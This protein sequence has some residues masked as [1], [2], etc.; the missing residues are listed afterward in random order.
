MQREKKIP[1][2]PRFDY[3]TQTAYK[4]LLECG[5]TRFPISPYDVL[6]ELKDYVVCIPWSKAKK[7]M[8]SE[9]PF[10]LH[11]L[12]AEGRTIRMRGTG[13]Y[14]IVYDDVT[15][16][17]PDRI[18]WTIMHEIGHIIL[19]HLVEFSETALN[20]GGMTSK[21]YGVL[22]VEAHYFAA[23]FLMPTAILKYYTGITVDEIALLFGVSDKAAEKKYKRVF[24]SDYLP[25]GKYDRLVIRNFYKFIITDADDAIYKSI[26]RTW[27]IPW[28]T[29]YVPVCRKCPDCYSYIDDP[30]AQHCSYC[31]AIMER[32][33]MYSNMFERMRVRT[34]FAK[35]PGTKHY[36]FPYC[37]NLTVNGFQYTK[38]TVCPVCLNH[39]FS[40]DATHCR[41][42]GTPLINE[43]ERIEVCFSKENGYETSANTWYPAYEK[44]Y[45]RLIA[46]TGSLR[47]EEWVDYDYWEFTKF[48]MRGVRSGVSM[49]LQS[50]L[51]YSHAFVDDNDDVYIVTDT[52]AAAKVMRAE[53]GTILSYLKQT[54]DIERSRLEVLV[55]YDL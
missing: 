6:D 50:A 16:N 4:F 13:M 22:E 41:I 17:S 42:C 54:D 38:V 27:G 34:E 2:K 28:K 51:L 19:G 44:R 29:K 21:Q 37:N 35:V 46:Y 15:V 55:A 20:R 49:D 25:T 39:E 1:D 9:D 53:M 14:Y 47:D 30:K 18:S 43:A 12:K 10:H 5:Y 48:M 3:V 32:S 8:K 7:V 33:E 45:Q 40:S 31:G 11:Q 36:G 24:E 52:A 26:Y 23:E